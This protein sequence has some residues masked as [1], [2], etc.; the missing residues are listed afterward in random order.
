MDKKTSYYFPRAVKE[1]EYVKLLQC[2][3]KF[4]DFFALYLTVGEESVDSGLGVG[5]KKQF[6]DDTLHFVRGINRL[7]VKNNQQVNRK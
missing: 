6:D 2:S 7:I 4:Q 5:Q 1:L 3:F